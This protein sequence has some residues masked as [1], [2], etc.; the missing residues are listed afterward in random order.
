[1]SIPTGDTALD[2]SSLTDTSAQETQGDMTKFRPFLIIASVVVG[3][4]L[5]LGSWMFYIDV[6]RSDRRAAARKSAS[7]S[8]GSSS[9]RPDAPQ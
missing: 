6:R 9:P 4:V 5:L 8:T 1:M 7:E 2:D 3:P